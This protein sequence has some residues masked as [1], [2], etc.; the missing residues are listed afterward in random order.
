[1][2]NQLTQKRDQAGCT[3]LTALSIKSRAGQCWNFF[4]PLHHDEQGRAHIPNGLLANL[5]SKCDG[6]DLRHGYSIHG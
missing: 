6:L 1:M 2:N 4:V 3:K 5:V